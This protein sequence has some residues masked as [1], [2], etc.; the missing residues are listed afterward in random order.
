MATLHGL[1]N[2]RIHSL[3]R[4]IKDRCNNPK[5]SNYKNYGGRGIKMCEAWGNDFLSFY[6]WAIENGYED[7]LSI[8]RIDVNGNY[9][10]LN[11]KWITMNEQCRNKRSTK[12]AVING[13]K[14]PLIE[15]A[16]LYGISYKT[17]TTRWYRG[18]RG[19]ALIEPLRKVKNNN[20]AS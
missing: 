17:I 6:K 5:A 8:E 2:T 11:C 10:P 14:K 18:L 15:W 3:W 1:S 7:H 16:E 4:K 13:E 19:C 20:H 9:E 12:Y